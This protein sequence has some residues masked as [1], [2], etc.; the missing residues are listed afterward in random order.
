M[1]DG[2]ILSQN[3]LSQVLKSFGKPE[4]LKFKQ[5]STSFRLKD[6]KL[7]NDN[8]QVNAED[9]NFQIKGWTSLTYI[10]SQNGNPME[11]S[12][13]GDFLNESLGRD[14]KKVLS[15]IGGGEP[16]IPVVIT[17][18]VQQPKIAIKMPKA[19]DLIQGIFGSDKK[20]R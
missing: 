10:A 13:T 17:G 1:N 8:V 9:L 5:I 4:T 7:Y 18:T 11:Y 19:G 3:V 6:E 20:K 2:T 12:I 16:L 14:A 15:I